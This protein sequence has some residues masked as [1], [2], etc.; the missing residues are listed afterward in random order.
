MSFSVA[1]RSVEWLYQVG[2]DGQL[3]A[4]TD[5]DRLRLSQTV[6]TTLTCSATVE[7]SDFRPDVVVTLGDRDITARTTLNATRRTPQTTDG[8]GHGEAANCMVFL[9]RDAMHPRY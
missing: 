8:D 5:G 1:P 9:P 3:V 4:A 6:A 7:R 2:D